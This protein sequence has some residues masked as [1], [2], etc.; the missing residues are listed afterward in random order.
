MRVACKSLAIGNCASVG[1]GGQP[2]AAATWHKQTAGPRTE[3]ASASAD[4]VAH[5]R[6]ANIT[7]VECV[8]AQA[9][10]RAPQS[11]ILGFGAFQV[12]ER[13]G[14]R[15]LSVGENVIL[16]TTSVATATMPLAAGAQLTRWPVAAPPPSGTEHALMALPVD[17]R[18]PQWSRGGGCLHAAARCCPCTRCPPSA[19]HACALLQAMALTGTGC[20]A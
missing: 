3:S 13:Y 8:V 1:D 20:G 15:K 12:L 6:Q 16:Q 7:C 2:Q 11:A 4:A 9:C 18:A 19:G 10:E 17:R 14:F 5:K